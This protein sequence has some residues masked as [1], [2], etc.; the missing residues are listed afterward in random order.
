MNSAN[1]QVVR[2]LKFIASFD[3]GGFGVQVSRLLR[4]KTLDVPTA[5][6]SSVPMSLPSPL[7][8]LAFKT[9][10]SPVIVGYFIAFSYSA[11]L[12]PSVLPGVIFL[13]SIAS[14]FSGFDSFIHRFSFRSITWQLN[15]RLILY[16][17]HLILIE[18]H[19]KSLW[20]QYVLIK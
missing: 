14:L 7:S 3:M 13:A 20:L 1:H 19:I 9:A 6:T 15:R 17:L 18:L 12:A 5:R 10:N 4:K 16:Q 8:N 2:S 11:L